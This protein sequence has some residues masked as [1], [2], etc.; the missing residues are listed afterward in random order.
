M[1]EGTWNLE[2][3]IPVRKTMIEKKLT[4]ARCNNEEE[5]KLLFLRAIAKEKVNWQKFSQHISLFF[6]DS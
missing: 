1:T 6:G 5:V 2:F 4:A 3:L